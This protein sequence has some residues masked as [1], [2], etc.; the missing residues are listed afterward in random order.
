METLCQVCTLGNLPKEEGDVQRQAVTDA[1]PLIQG[2]LQ[3]QWDVAASPCSSP[4][5]NAMTNMAHVQWQA[6]PD[7]ELL[8]NDPSKP[9][10]KINSP[11]QI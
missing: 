6:V 11:L 1:G 5:R 2:P 8:I 3:A 4:K 7:L 9:E 10:V